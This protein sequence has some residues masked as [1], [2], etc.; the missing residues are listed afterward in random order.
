MTQATRS[1]PKC[2]SG[3]YLFRG[4]KNIAATTEQPAAIET[5][6]LCR[7]CGHA[8]KERGAVGQGRTV[9]QGHD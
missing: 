6:Y 8:W 1:C 3:D 4:R 5:R 7:H 9:S 2:G